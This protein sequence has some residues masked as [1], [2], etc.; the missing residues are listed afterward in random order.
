MARLAVAEN[1]NRII[2]DSDWI[3]FITAKKAP[4]PELTS[5]ATHD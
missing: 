5:A 1:T 3:C 2:F 4:T